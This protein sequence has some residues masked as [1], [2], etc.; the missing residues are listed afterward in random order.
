[1]IFVIPA[2]FTQALSGDGVGVV[3]TAAIGQTAQRSGGDPPIGT[4]APRQRSGG[5]QGHFSSLSSGPSMSSFLPEL[6]PSPLFRERP[7][8]ACGSL[9]PLTTTGLFVLSGAPR[10]QP[11]RQRRRVQLLDGRQ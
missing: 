7:V 6:R 10:R 2:A 1:M 4:K 11:V 8:P 9:S 3:M 5:G